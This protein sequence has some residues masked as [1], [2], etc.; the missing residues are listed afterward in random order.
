MPV[1]TNSLTIHTD[2]MPSL[3]SPHGP[4]LSEN[5]D[6]DMQHHPLDHSDNIDGKSNLT[7]IQIFPKQSGSMNPNS[8]P[9]PRT[10]PPQLNI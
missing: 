8:T 7:R 9:Q 6:N 10:P 2:D 1:Q 3:M 4:M 5:A